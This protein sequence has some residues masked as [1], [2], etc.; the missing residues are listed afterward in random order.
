MIC[1]IGMCL[2][3]TGCGKTTNEKIIG[4]WSEIDKGLGSIEFFED[5][6]FLYTSSR[7][8]G[9]W[10]ILQDGRLK[11]NGIG[12]GTNRLMVCTIV[13]DGDDMTWTNEKGKSIR[14]AR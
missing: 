13:V 7:E 1:V 10:V 6:S 11:M 5:G 14:F 3:I 9:K 8:S 12:Q 2:M 4:K